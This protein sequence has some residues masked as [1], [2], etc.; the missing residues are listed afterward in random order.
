MGYQNIHFFGFDSCMGEEDAHHAY[1]FVT[2][3]EVV[4]E[5]YQ[6]RVGSLFDGAEG[7]SN[8]FYCAGYHLAQAEQ[9]KMFYSQYGKS[10][11]PTF[12]GGGL[13]AATARV[14]EE[15]SHRIALMSHV[16]GPPDMSN[17][18]MAA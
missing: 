5:I 8:I 13:L 1:D 2:K 6:I 18:N 16:L 7:A 12:H 14:V 17:F 10:F 11:V 3:D 15:E 9:F 4:G